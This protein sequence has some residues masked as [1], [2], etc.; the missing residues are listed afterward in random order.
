MKAEVKNM[1]EL[2]GS[3]GEGGGQILRTALALSL[4]TGKSFR[5]N[6]IRAK[7]PKPGLMRQHLACVNAAV[8]VGG[9]LDQTSAV[10]ATG[11]AV[12]R[13]E[14]IATI[15]LDLGDA[16]F[17]ALQAFV[18]RLEQ[19]AEMLSAG[20][21]GLLE[22]LVGAL[23]ELGL[24]VVEQA[25][26]DLGE[27]RGQRFFGGDDLGQP[28]LERQ[29]TLARRRLVRI[30]CAHRRVALGRHGEQLLARHVMLIGMNLGG[31]QFGHAT[32]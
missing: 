16:F 23:Q 27:L 31:R 8:A 32:T 12:Q 29:L 1:V 15:G 26:A 4:V 2:D 11:Q 14:R 30:E 28:C 25:L 5:M 13:A 19:G 24:G 6:N 22:P 17:V 21:F 18:D 9:G 3:Q 20:R 10:N 7:R